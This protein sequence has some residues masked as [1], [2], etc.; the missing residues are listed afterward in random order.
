ME[1]WSRCVN[2]EMP[3]ADTSTVVGHPVCLM[4]FVMLDGPMRCGSSGEAQS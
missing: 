3:E 4:A 1:Q 2:R